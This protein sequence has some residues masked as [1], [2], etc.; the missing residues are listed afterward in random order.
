VPEEI[1]VLLLAEDSESDVLLM[2]EAFAKAEAP[3]RLQVVRDGHQAVADLKGETDYSLRETHLLA[4]AVLLELKM[5]GKDGFEVLPWV[6]LQP[7]FKRLIIIVL[8]SSS[9]GGK[10]DR[11]YDLGAK[12]YLVKP[13]HFPSP[14]EGRGRGEGLF[15]LARFNPQARRPRPPASALGGCG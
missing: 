1:L 11:A 7:S 9:R 13:G 6:R 15:G 14:S 4:I 12:F 10:A 5:P 2:Q 8:S 3:T